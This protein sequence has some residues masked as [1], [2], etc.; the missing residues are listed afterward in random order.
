VGTVRLNAAHEEGHIVIT[1]QDDGEGI[2]P[3]RVRQVAVRRGVLSEEGAA[4]LDDDEAVAL[5][6]APNFTT[7]ERVT[8]VSGRGVGMD[9]VQTNVKRIGGSV[10]VESGVGSGTTF[11][12]TLPLTLAILQAMMVA[13]GEDVYAVPLA[14]IIE[15]QYLSDVQVNNVKGSPTIVSRGAVLPLIYLREFYAH[16]CL[17]DA[18]P[19]GAKLAVVTVAWGKLRV[20]LIVDKLVG[21]QEIVVKSLSPIVGN[22]PGLSG[23]TIMG[24]GR[25]ALIVDVP[26]L[27]GAAVS[28]QRAM[29]AR[30]QGVEA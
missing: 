6:F 22:V 4:Q 14:G 18:P 24:D 11:R 25:I 20:G 2:D 26:G 30:R 13:L 28:H 7:S 3:D 8:G 21:K 12:I 1:V 9:V 19:D 10:A 17:S 23:C 27:I 5:I 15:S 29:Q 16:S